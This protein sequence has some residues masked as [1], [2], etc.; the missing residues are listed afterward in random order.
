MPVFRTQIAAG[1]PV[2]VTHPEMRRYFMT[3]LEAV[4]LVIQAGAMGQGGIFVLDMGQPVRIADLAENMIR[5]CGYEPDVDIP[6]VFTG[7][8]PG[9][10]ISEELFADAEA[11]ESTSHPR[12]WRAKPGLGNDGDRLRWCLADLGSLGV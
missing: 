9:E 7:A 11:V 8:R 4:Q 5:P 2:T 10:K 3:T 6:I 1:A 12:I